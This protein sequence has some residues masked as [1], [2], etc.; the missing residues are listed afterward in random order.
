M[1]RLPALSRPVLLQK[2]CLHKVFH[3][4]KQHSYH[5]FLFFA[6]RSFCFFN[7]IADKI[8]VH[9]ALYKNWLQRTSFSK[10]SPFSSSPVNLPIT[11]IR[12]RS[13]VLVGWVLGT[14]REVLVRVSRRRSMRWRQPRRRCGWLRHRHRNWLQRSNYFQKHSWHRFPHYYQ[15]FDFT[16]YDASWFSMVLEMRRKKDHRP[17]SW[18]F[19]F[20]F[21]PSA[22]YTF[23]I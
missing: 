19:W 9:S 11:V 12:L 14:L 17:V 10:T 6:V 15:S 7:R 4:L 21:S 20:R 13:K 8:Y 1:M 5:N 16:T 2:L 22:Q 23:L 3:I 18:G